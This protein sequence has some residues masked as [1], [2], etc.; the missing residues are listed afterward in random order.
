MAFTEAWDE[1]VPT[2]NE[3]IS[4]GASRIRA[5]RK[6]IRERINVEHDFPDGSESARHKFVVGSGAA[7]DAITDWVDGSVFFRTDVSAIQVRDS[8]ETSDWRTYYT[9]FLGEVKMWT[10]LVGAIPDG[11]GLCDGGDVNGF[12]T[13]DL[14]GKFIVGFDTGNVDYDTLGIG[15]ADEGGEETHVLTEAELPENDPGEHSHTLIADEDGTG[16]GTDYPTATEAIARKNAQAA[17]T[18][19]RIHQAPTAD[20]TIGK[21]SETQVTAFG[22]GSEPP[23]ADAHENRPPYYAM[24]FIVYVGLEAP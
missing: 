18:D 2:D 6:N 10:G 9:A 4:Q 16:A 21:S 20:A 24:A 22:G 12:T 19:Y 3:N 17:T 23:D 8:T 7:R 11:W 13:P 15:L 1:G 5:T 14:S